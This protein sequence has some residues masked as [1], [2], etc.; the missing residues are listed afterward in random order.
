MKEISRQNEMVFEAVSGF[1]RALMEGKRFA[2]LSLVGLMALWTLKNAGPGM[3]REGPGIPMGD[4]AREMDM[5]KPA[6]TQMVNGLEKKGLVSRAADARNRRF[7][8][9]SLTDRGEALLEEA[10]AYY[11]RL[12]E[13]VLA[14]AGEQ[15]VAT[16]VRV[17]RMMTQ[18]LR[19]EQ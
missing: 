13:R 9:V 12:S 6:A 2:G 18:V 19:E 17:I 3:R 16:M 8:L 15:D 14:Q 4:L 11:C 10:M 1:R 5:T 7:V